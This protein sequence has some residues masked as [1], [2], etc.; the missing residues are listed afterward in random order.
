MQGE[1]YD[2]IV[3]GAGSAGCAVAGAALA[4]TAATACCCSRPGRKDSNPWIHIP[5]GYHKTFNNPRVN[6]MFDSE[7]ERRAQQPH[8]VPAAR[9]GAGRHQLD[10]RHGLHAR[11]RRPTTTN[12]A[13]AAARAGT[14]IRRPAV[15]QQGRGPGARRRRVPR[16]RRS[17]AGLQ[18]SLRSAT[19]AEAMHRGRP[20]RPA[21][22]PIR[23]STARP[24]KASATTR[25]TITTGAALEHA[26]RP[27]CAGA[28]TRKNLT[29]ATIAHATRV[30]IENG[31]AVGVEY[32]TPRGPPDGARQR[33]GD[34]LGR[35]LRLAAAAACC[36][37]SGP[38]EHLQEHGHRGDA[39]PAGRRR[40]PARPFQ[41]LRRLAMRRS[42]SR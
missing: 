13:S 36:R 22:R 19:S 9:Q 1:A 21:S 31:R 32:R 10:Q 24:R 35:R 17:A 28:K 41:H 23:T 8:H 30:L 5:L 6:W 2:F 29:V 33:R 38:A 42:P 12:G 25:R 16:R 20:S 40:Q 18:P 3:T 11:Q 15:L 4:R 27:I 26:R 37:A 39:R 14:T 7:P 34:R